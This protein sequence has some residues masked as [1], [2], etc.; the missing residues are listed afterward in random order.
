MKA[1][2]SF[3]AVLF[4]NRVRLFC[5]VAMSV[6]FWQAC[7]SIPGKD[8]H[9]EYLNPVLKRI[10]TT[11]NNLP[12]SQ[13][14]FYLDSSFNALQNP[15]QG[16][17]YVRDSMKQVLYSWLKR[18]YIR[19]VA[20]TDTMMQMAGKR[21]NEEKYAQ[22]Y[23]RTLSDKGDCFRN[24]KRYYE[25]FH[26][27]TMAQDA[28]LNYVKNKCVM[29]EY[30]G[31]IAVL[32]FAQEKYLSGAAYFLKQYRELTTDCNPD[33]YKH[34]MS[35]EAALNNV[36]LCYLRAGMLDSAGY[37]EKAALNVIAG[38]EDK[39]PER[40]VNTAYAKA[41]IYG[42]QAEVLALKGQ[43]PEAEELYKK[44]IAGTSV[45][46][47]P[48]TQLTQA[49]LAEIYLKENK[50]EQAGQALEN[51]KASLDT[52]ANETQLIK[53]Y[54]LKVKY[55]TRKRQTEQAL[56]YQDT[57]LAIR[58]SVEA[59]DKKFATVDL[60]KEFENLELKYSNEV[61]QKESKLKNLYLTIAILIVIMAAAIATLVWHNLNRAR[62]LNLQVQQKNGD[63]QKAL[64]SLEQSHHENSRI[65]SIVA[66]DL[67][68]PISAINNLIY[69]L[70]KKDYP[71]DLKEIFELIKTAC[72]NSMALIKDVLQDKKE[73]GIIKKELVDMK[74]LLEYCV[75]LLQAKAD[76][77]KQQLTL[78]AEHAT[79]MLN[80]QKMWRVVSN[81]VNNAIKFSPEHAVIDIK[82][83]R[84]EDTVLLSVHDKGIGIPGELK[85]KIFTLSPEASRAGTSGEKSYGLGLSISE[86][87]IKEHQGKIWFDSI[88]GKGSVFYVELP[89]LN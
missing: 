10:D 4:I 77:K 5:L 2:P 71:G 58:D 21:L 79:L 8:E 33:G 61:L 70:L 87:I 86:K 25:S 37:Y 22:R 28:V 40:S 72:G 59:R 9:P 74:K 16:D 54:K 12:L 30:S 68:S 32:M 46:D 36:A 88:N 76:E 62:K 51:L 63:L 44:S 78:Q 35:L 39:F 67:K 75:D 20:Y 89:Y 26:Y 29:A 31:S 84:K 53:W 57:Y 45:M 65:I 47:K 11:F 73:P 43:F 42:D 15:G 83:Q 85:D 34:L 80:R 7:K 52:V 56:M 64:S 81:I 48:Y 66:H 19:A 69:S 24:M 3:C 17:F 14:L 6:F 50:D 49:R 60:G 27:Y 1:L 55:H 38:G 18:D 82:L 13:T 41:V 23:A